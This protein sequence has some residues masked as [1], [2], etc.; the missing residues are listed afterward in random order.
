MAAWGINSSE[1]HFGC[2]SLF[3][4]KASFCALVSSDWLFAPQANCWKHKRCSNLV[5][6]FFLPCQFCFKFCKSR[7]GPN[8]LAAANYKNN[9]TLKLTWTLP[10]GGVGK[11]FLRTSLWLFF[12]VLPQS[13]IVRAG[14]RRLAFCPPSQ[15]LKT[16]KMLKP[17]LL[18]LSLET[19]LFLPCQFRF[20]LCKSCSE[21][22]S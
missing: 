9:K 22:Y 20:K 19:W 8:R 11:K 3:C 1:R 10:K 6:C 18:I 15:L 14:F 2:F 7:S 21:P 16:Q 4:L 13:F 17:H 12:F 5:C